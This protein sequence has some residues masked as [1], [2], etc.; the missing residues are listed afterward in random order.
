MQNIS[1]IF[2]IRI[3]YMIRDL[4]LLD[5]CV[6][7]FVPLQRFAM[8]LKDI[9]LCFSAAKHDLPVP[10]LISGNNLGVQNTAKEMHLN[11]YNP[12]CWQCTKTHSK[13]HCKVH[14][15]YVCLS[16]T[17]NSL[18][19]NVNEKITSICFKKAKIQ[20][21][22][23]LYLFYLIIVVPLYFLYLFRH[24]LKCLYFSLLRNLIYN[25]A[26]FIWNSC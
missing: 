6:P 11:E 5:N 23:E 22:A 18:K 12:S 9:D 7:L 1:L 24:V 3:L 10:I 16:H 25:A 2:Q 13:W 14:Q 4:P 19:K 26:P 15:F 8:H 20:L 17:R 21:K